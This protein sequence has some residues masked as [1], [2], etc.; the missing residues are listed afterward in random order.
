MKKLIMFVMV[1]VIATS[2]TAL[3]YVDDAPDFAGCPG[4]ASVF[5]EFVNE[6]C[7]PTS[8]SADPPYYYDPDPAI[9]PTF[10][11]RHWDD[12][13]NDAGWGGSYGGALWTY[14]NGIY[15]VLSE[16]SL[17]QSI[18]ERSEQ[19]YLRQYFQIVHTEVPDL[20]EVKMGHRCADS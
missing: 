5:W 19:P 9:T 2:A 15:T 11:S 13:T 17:N 1:L 18:P 3:K 12:P 16:D 20:P 14:S 6:G 4:S 10:G 8:D 7:M